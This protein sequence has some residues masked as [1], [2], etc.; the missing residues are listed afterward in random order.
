MDFEKIFKEY[1]DHL[2]PKLDTYEPIRLERNRTSCIAIWP[3]TTARTTRR[4]AGL[5]GRGPRRLV[6]TAR[7]SRN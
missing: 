5:G 4:F 6:T 1:Q 7:C 2:A 3:D